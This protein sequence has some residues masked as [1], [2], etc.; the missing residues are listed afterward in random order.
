MNTLQHTDLTGKSDPTAVLWT[1]RL[2]GAVV[3]AVSLYLYA[4][5]DFSWWLFAALILA[6]DLAFLGYL[7]NPAFGAWCYNLAH[8]YT[9]AF[10]VW[11][12]LK[13]FGWNYADAVTLIWVTHIGID[14]L[15]GYGLK[16]SDAFKH[17]HL[18]S[19]PDR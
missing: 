1:L 7:R 9:M 12:L 13:I 4:T 5:G 17:T 19:W 11:L 6:P 18:T 3:A 10:I 8:T 16:Y 14:R 15:L 2:E